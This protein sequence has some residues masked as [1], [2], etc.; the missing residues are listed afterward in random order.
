MVAEIIGHHETYNNL[1]HTL[2]KTIPTIIVLG[3]VTV[4]LY[5]YAS[6]DNEH[7][8]LGFDSEVRGHQVASNSSPTSN[9][10]ESPQVEISTKN[11]HKSEKSI[12]VVVE[13]QIDALPTEKD[14]LS[15][16]G[17]T[18]DSG[19]INAVL[20][21]DDY[22]KKIES[23]K[24]EQLANPVAM[25][26]TQDYEDLINI[27]PEIMDDIELEL[28]D[29]SCGLQVCMGSVD[30]FGGSDSWRRLVTEHL[31]NSEAVSFGAMLS[32]P[33]QIDENRVEHRFVFSTTPG[34]SIIGA[35]YEDGQ[36]IYSPGNGETGGEEPADPAG[37]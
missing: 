1:E 6:W 17:S 15:K 32:Y 10:S 26:I 36:L 12:D 11:R 21:S 37:G 33:L 4:G 18:F 24:Q 7:S 23:L 27:F 9:V 5:Y 25:E 35:P 34:D 19:Y 31:G 29:I 3:L 14:L 16:N 13:Q 28:N 30:T 2:K 20:S 8:E 22:F